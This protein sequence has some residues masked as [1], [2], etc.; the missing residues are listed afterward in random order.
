[1]SLLW[2][3]LDCS[4]TAAKIGKI[5]LTTIQGLDVRCSLNYQQSRSQG[6][7]SYRPLGRARRGVSSLAPGGGKMRD[8]LGTRLS[9]ELKL[10]RFPRYWEFWRSRI[11]ACYD[12]QLWFNDDFQSVLCSPNI[13]VSHSMKF[14][15]KVLVTSRIPYPWGLFFPNSFIAFYSCE[16]RCY[17]K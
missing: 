8:G 4:L 17:I 11:S 9:Y 16:V 15:W 5:F 2:D 1:M 6:L 12:L 14:E 7:S 3:L 13:D 10:R